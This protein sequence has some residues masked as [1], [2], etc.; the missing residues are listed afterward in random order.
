MN[1]WGGFV[2]RCV[3]LYHLTLESVYWVETCGGCG[4]CGDCGDVGEKMWMGLW[5]PKSSKI[6]DLFPKRDKLHWVFSVFGCW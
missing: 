6:Y 1:K 5:G 4:G 3:D 2:Y